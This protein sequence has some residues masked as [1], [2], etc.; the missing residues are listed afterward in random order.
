LEGIFVALTPEMNDDFTRVGKGTP[1]GEL[2]RRYWLP[3]APANELA[4]E[5]RKKRLRVLGEDLVLYRDKHDQLGLI[6]E[7]C[8]HRHASLYFGFLGEEGGLRCAYHGWRFDTDGTCVE[9]PFE[10]ADSKLLALACRPHYQVQE[11]AGILWGYMGP[12][13]APLLPRW[14]LL[15]RED[16]LRAVT[17]LPMHYCNW[18]QAQ[19]N[20]HDPVHTIYLHGRM[21]Q[22]LY[23]AGNEGAIA[24]YSRPLE[25]YDFEVCHEPA[26]SGIRKTREFGGEKAQRELG[27]PAIFP[28][29]LVNPQS[30]KIVMHL[31]TPVDDEHTYILWAE[32]VPN[33]DGSPAN[34][35]D[36]DIPVTYLPHPRR[37]DGEYDL[38]TFVNHDM[39]AWETQGAIYDRSTELLGASDRGITLFRK[40]LRE[41]I[42]KVKAGLDPAGVIRDPALNESIPVGKSAADQFRLRVA[43]Q[44]AQSGARA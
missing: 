15:V 23:P 41:E 14:D 10:P 13:P 32:F 33:A 6:P 28:N 35:R 8:P 17:V 22:E 3:L 39:M 9:Q 30:D 42:D 36:E 19:E 21:L 43:F 5:P 38:T 27:H 2:F 26:W 31:R 44:A 7:R 40:M 20:S 24:Y 25:K 18:L 16:G 12:D 11:L 29:A 4:K 1:C 37:P 34:Q